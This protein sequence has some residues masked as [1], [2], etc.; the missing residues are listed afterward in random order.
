[1]KWIN[2]KEKLP[3][4]GEYIIIKLPCGYDVDVVYGVFVSDK[5]IDEKFLSNNCVDKD[6]STFIEIFDWFKRGKCKYFV[7]CPNASDAC[8]WTISDKELTSI[9]EETCE[10]CYWIPFPDMPTKNKK[11]KV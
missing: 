1:M 9:D 11:N 7:H 5:N 10:T 4:H 2:F 8:S 6:E 3:K